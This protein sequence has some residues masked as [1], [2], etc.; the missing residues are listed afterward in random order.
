MLE[1]KI[2]AESASEFKEILAQLA[3][4]PALPAIKATDGPA[5]DPKP[6]AK[7][8]ATKPKS[9]KKAEPEP[10]K[11]QA[12]DA[13]GADAA[14]TETEAAPADVEKLAID[15]LRKYALAYVTALAPS[16]QDERRKLFQEI[17]KKGGVD[18]FNSLPE[19]KFAEVKAFIDEKAAAIE[20]ES[21]RPVYGAE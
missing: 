13:E 4:A 9:T 6:A 3:S 17:L 5:D 2:T 18:K 19:D 11:E 10:E 15:P 8:A 14:E 20:D 1:L 21:A 12:A 7:P 16:D